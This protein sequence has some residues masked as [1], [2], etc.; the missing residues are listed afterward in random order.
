MLYLTGRS[1]GAAVVINGPTATK[2]A[3]DCSSVETD[4]TSSPVF[5]GKLFPDIKLSDVEFTGVTVCAVDPAHRTAMARMPR[6]VGMIVSGCDKQSCEGR[7]GV[8]ASQ[9]CRA[10]SYALTD[11]AEALRL[12]E[13]AMR[14]RL[15]SLQRT[16]GDPPTTD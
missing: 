9:A 5:H 2:G 16:R 1:G 10:T 15:S 13:M 14:K 8:E 6:N 12:R 4:S 3:A 7:N 11:E